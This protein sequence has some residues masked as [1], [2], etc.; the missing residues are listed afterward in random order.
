MSLMPA[1]EIAEMTPMDILDEAVK[2]REWGLAIVD[3]LGWTR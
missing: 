3:G 1:D 2:A